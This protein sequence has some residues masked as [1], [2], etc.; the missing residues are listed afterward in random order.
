MYI[1]EALKYRLGYASDPAIDMLL[2]KSKIAEIKV[3]ELD[4][5]IRELEQNLELVKVTRGAIAEQYK[6]R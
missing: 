6:I 3:R 1:P 4:L 2:D 5:T